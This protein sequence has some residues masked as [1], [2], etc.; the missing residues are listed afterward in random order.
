M[1]EKA[2]HKH[3]YEGIHPW[4][5]EVKDLPKIEVEFNHI[6][7]PGVKIE[8]TKGRTVIKNNGRLGTIHETYTIEDGERIELTQDVINHLNKLTYPEAGRVK[9]RFICTPV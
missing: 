2:K 8:F 9:P 5:R 4:E 1:T 6:Q 7:Q 3:P